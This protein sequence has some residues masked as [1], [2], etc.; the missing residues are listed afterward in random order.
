MGAGQ[1][2]LAVAAR[3][4]ASGIDTLIVERWNRVGDNWRQRHRSLKLHN[5]IWANHLPYLPFP[6][7]WPV[8]LPK[9]K[10]ADWF[11]HYADSLELNVWTD[12]EFRAATC[13]PSGHWTV[14]LNRAGE[15]RLLS[16]KHIVMATGVSG[17]PRK[18]TLAG[19]ED[20]RGTVVHSNAYTDG[21]DFKGK[22]ALVIGT[23]T[24][25]HDIAED[26]FRCGAGVT[27]MQRSATTVISLEP[28]CQKYYALYHGGL[29]PTE[30]CD[31]VRLATPYPM[32]RKWLVALTE[33]TTKLDREL[34]AGLA[35][36]GFKTDPGEDGTGFSMKYRRYGGGYYIDVGCSQLI[37][38][39]KIS[40]V[41][42]DD[43]VRFTDAGILMSDGSV[44]SVDVVV[45]ATGYE[46]FQEVV[47]RY[48]GREIADKVGPVWGLNNEGELRNICTRTAQDGLWFLAG[49]LPEARIL[50]KYLA[51]QI[52]AAEGK[53]AL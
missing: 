15:E 47:L 20:F 22:S 19:F 53:I 23:G 38:D 36:A 32:A 6:A 46:A 26:L 30:E 43:F 27:M 16:P 1:A 44:R 37:V 28:G 45:M 40:I 29:R 51:I 5:E 10:V 42:A 39:G 7:S 12:T 50:S 52:E 41:Q 35:R 34:L 33:E 14:S 9:D 24:T 48:F 11:E 18:P 8:F 31:L 49:G 21:S 13:D 2:G 25:G 17:A 4:K 3:L